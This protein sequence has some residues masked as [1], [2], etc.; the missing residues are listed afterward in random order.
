MRT[1]R[2]S[3]CLSSWSL[4]WTRVVARSF[5]PRSMA[6]TPQVISRVIAARSFYDVLDCSRS[7]SAIEIKGA[8]HKLSLLLHPDKCAEPN[9][10]AAFQRLSEAHAV[11]GDTV[12][13]RSYDFETAHKQQGQHSMTASRAAP[14]SRPSNCAMSSR[15]PREAASAEEI[16]ARAEAKWAIDV[17]ELSIEVANLKREAER[18]RRAED[19]RRQRHENE[20]IEQKRH[21][22]DARAER[23]AIKRH[24]EDRLDEE[25]RRQQRDRAEAAA[26]LALLREELTAERAKAE[27]LQGRLEERE[28]AL[29]AFYATHA[30]HDE[31]PHDARPHARPQ[32]ARARLSTALVQPPPQPPSEGGRTAPGAVAG[33]V[34][35]PTRI[36]E[37]A[38]P[39]VGAP[40]LPT[41]S[42]AAA[43]RKV[44]PS[45]T[46]SV[47]K[48]HFGNY[49]VVERD[50]AGGYTCSAARLAA[51]DRWAGHRDASQAAAAELRVVH[52]RA[53]AGGQSNFAPAGR[54]GVTAPAGLMSS[55]LLS[56][57]ERLG[58]GRFRAAF[59]EEE[60]YDLPLLRSM[61]PMLATNMLEL[62]L[63]ADDVERLRAAL[64]TT[65]I[66]N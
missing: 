55:A 39:D 19:E 37:E 5:Q 40:A 63:D 22:A 14:S 46:L 8:F 27:R 57:L 49:K 61:G 62:G 65:L 10:E 36:A 6:S 42:A 35:A 17:R 59:E 3:L 34:W 58:L 4:S 9:A 21:A 51:E 28:A 44:S 18:N 56:L 52:T 12:R 2:R 64:G 26:K 7:A 15:L 29:H 11:L 23:D 30:T 16:Q 47:E 50:A 25:V 66:G 38:A 24:W 45:T 31:Q 32:D 54:A 60:L 41:G 48:D 43:P 13:R 33:C 53:Q 1:A 20:L